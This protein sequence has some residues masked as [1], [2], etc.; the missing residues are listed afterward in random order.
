[1]VSKLSSWFWLQPK[2]HVFSQK[3]V[4]RVISLQVLMSSKFYLCIFREAFQSLHLCFFVKFP[5]PFTCTSFPMKVIFFDI[6]QVLAIQILIL[7]TT[8]EAS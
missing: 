1:M 7:K 5:Y 4:T 3:Q 8:D 6:P 2:E